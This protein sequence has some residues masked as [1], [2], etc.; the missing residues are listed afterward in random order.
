MPVP[1][2]P[3]RDIDN[4]SGLFEYGTESESDIQRGIS[5]LQKAYMSSLPI[6]PEVREASSD[7]KVYSAHTIEMLQNIHN[8]VDDVVT[9]G[10]EAT[11]VRSN[12]DGMGLYRVPA[13]ISD[14]DM[15]TLKAQGLIEGRSRVVAFTK[16]GELALRNHWFKTPNALI[17]TRT[18]SRFV[19]P[20]ENVGRTASVK[21]SVKRFTSG[22]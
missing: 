12:S 2:K 5:E 7:K 21:P 17:A 14:Y 13:N 18:K 20:S 16:A 9:A 6:S 10:A 4:L 15:M 8:S 22:V 19:H 3:V 11:G 1:I